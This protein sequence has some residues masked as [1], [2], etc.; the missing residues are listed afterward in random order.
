VQRRERFGAKLYRREPLA[1]YGGSCAKIGRTT[2]IEAPKRSTQWVLS[3]SKCYE[4][5]K[6]MEK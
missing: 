4:S 6:R 3:M 5:D 1:E 2:S